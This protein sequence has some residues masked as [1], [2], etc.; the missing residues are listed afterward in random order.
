LKTDSRVILWWSTRRQ[1]TSASRSW[2]APSRR[3][4]RHHLPGVDHVPT[5]GPLPR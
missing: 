5:H 1:S 4:Q 3:S 2:T